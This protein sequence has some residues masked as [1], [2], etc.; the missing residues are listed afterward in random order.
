M[1]EFR[2]PEIGEGVTEATVTA[3]FAEAG[4]PARKDEP[5]VEL[6]TDKAA[7]ELPC[8]FDGK[9]KD[10]AVAVGDTVKVGGLIAVIEEGSHA[11]DSKTKPDAAKQPEPAPTPAGGV[12]KPAEKNNPGTAKVEEPPPAPAKPVEQKKGRPASAPPSSPAAKSLARDLGINISEVKS[13]AGGRVS[14]EDVRAHAKDLIN[15]PS[16]GG[17]GG[18]PDFSPWGEI[19]RAPVST[20]GKASAQQL[21]KSWRTIPHVTHHDSADITELEQLRKTFSPKAEEAGGKLTVTAIMVKVA[22]SALGV[23]TKFN[24]SFDEARGEMIFKK[25]VNIGV[26]VDTERGLMVPVIKNASEK[27]IVEISIELSDLAKRAREKN[28]KPDEL[29]GATFT[30]SNL[31]GIGGDSFTPIINPPEVA[32]LGLARANVRPVF[33]AASGQFKPRTIL[34]LSLSYDHRMIDGAEAARFARWVAE[35]VE[36]PFKLVFEG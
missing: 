22:A 24:G 6:E 16:A 32:I 12:E 5:F 34:P 31:G 27:N 14:L 36:E 18:L 23:F 25:Y 9:V 35:A 4:K 20:V 26:A 11:P 13:A 7:F 3:V 28:I 2:L 30:V 21:S 8:Q 19:E 17:A 33:D 29:A 15:S 10:I 1:I